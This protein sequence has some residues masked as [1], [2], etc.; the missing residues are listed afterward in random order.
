MLFSLCSHIVKLNGSQ[1]SVS[2]C[3]FVWLQE[4]TK[5]AETLLRSVVAHVHA[6]THTQCT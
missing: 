6:R 5:E 2:V 4:E 1:M 3:G